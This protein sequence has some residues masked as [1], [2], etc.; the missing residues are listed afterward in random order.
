MTLSKTQLAIIALILASVIWGASF[1]IYKWSLE[2]VPPFL[3]IFVRFFGASLLILPFV[4]K[5]LKINKKDIPK[6]LTI[7]ILGVSVQ[8]SLLFLGLQLTPSINAPIITAIGPIVLIIAATIFLKEKLKSKILVGVTIS[9]L[10]ALIIIIQ[11]VLEAGGITGSFLG[12]FLIFLATMISVATVLLMKKLINTYS[13]LSI[14]FWMFFIGS[15]SLIP[16][17]IYELQTITIV[18]LISPQSLFGLIYAIIFP[19]AI[20][21]ALFVFGLK[22]LT[23]GEVGVFDYIIPIATVAVAI[24]LLNETITVTYLV[25]AILIFIGVFIAEGHIHYRHH[26]FN[27]FYHN[28]KSLKKE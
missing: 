25:S 2:I 19:A 10:G 6:I 1:P 22:Y 5:N 21:H 27:H 8:A 7:A 26:H 24:P 15:L 20:A 13:P 16:F 28:N 3:F 18:Q 23:V 11:P 4:Y 14:T 17:V 12:N 9:L